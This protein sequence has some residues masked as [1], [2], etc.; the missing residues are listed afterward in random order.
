LLD[1]GSRCCIGFVGQ[2]CGVEDRRLARRGSI[3]S[4]SNL[5]ISKENWPSWLLGGSA[6]AAYTTNDDPW[7]SDASREAKLQ[8]IFARNGDE[9]VFEN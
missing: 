1:D 6:P 9:I 4:V 3:R 2:Q 5:E 8:E 7:I